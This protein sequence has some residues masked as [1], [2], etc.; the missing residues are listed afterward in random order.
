[1]RT[2][3]SWK[4]LDFEGEPSTPLADRIALDSPVRDV[5]GMLRSFDY[6]ARHQ[7]VDRPPGDATTQLA[8]RAAEWADRNRRAFCDGYTAA[9]GRDPRDDA[10]LLRAYE[11]DKAVYEAVYESRLRP[12]WLAIPMA[13]VDRLAAEALAG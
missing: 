10:V 11:I 2:T 5:A 6:A 12:S 8:Y 3:R 13:A 4:L 9:A 1:M 7:L